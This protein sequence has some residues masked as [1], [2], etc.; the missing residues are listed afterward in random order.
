MQ[1]VE[2]K[3][4]YDTRSR[5]LCVFI[6]ALVDIE[7]KQLLDQKQM[8]SQNSQQPITGIVLCVESRLK[9]GIVGVKALSLFNNVVSLDISD[10]NVDRE[11]ITVLSQMKLLKY[12]DIGDNDV[13]DEE[14]KIIAGTSNRNLTTLRARYNRIG[15]EGAKALANNRNFLSLYLRGNSIGVAG[16]KAFAE[17]PRLLVLEL[18]SNKIGTEG[19][20]LLSQNKSLTYLEVD[21]NS[22]ADEGAIA[23]AQ[24]TTL[25]HLSIGYNH[26]QLAAAKALSENTTIRHLRIYSSS[27]GEAGVKCYQDSKSL[28]SLDLWNVAADESCAHL[29][30]N[31][32]T[33][34]Y[35]H[36]PTSDET[37]T[38]LI[39]EMMQKNQE[40]ISHK[41]NRFVLRLRKLFSQLEHKELSFEGI[42]L[43]RELVIHIMT[44]LNEE[45]YLK[46]SGIDNVVDIGK[47]EWQ[48]RQCICYLFQLFTN[49]FFLFNDLNGIIEKV[50][51]PYVATDYRTDFRMR[52]EI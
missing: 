30:L 4:C 26:L 46:L 51:R 52:Q 20:V 38:E 24:N 33:L 15:C 6:R 49:G 29:L 25:Q 10:N 48:V 42:Q 27:F 17:S 35:L 13:G 43:P 18:Y 21:N 1:S 12:L 45:F 32:Q 22:V 2:D 40:R 7:L 50:H 23:L 39:N 19:A 8:Q 9:V 41:R 28:L 11:G 14:A 3:T 34:T 16:A 5:T 31:N 37:L 47:T 44:Y 36:F